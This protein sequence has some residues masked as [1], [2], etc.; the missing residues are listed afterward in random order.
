MKMNCPICHNELSKKWQ[1]PQ[2]TKALAPRGQWS[3]GVCGGLFTRLEV[4]AAGKPVVAIPAVN[5]S[6]AAVVD[7]PKAQE[8]VLG[9][10]EQL[11]A[12]QMPTCL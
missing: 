6:T 10:E 12:A 9:E 3:C 2:S 7:V 11:S 4:Q 8:P 5:P 1:P